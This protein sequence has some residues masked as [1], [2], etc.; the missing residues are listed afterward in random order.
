VGTAVVK[1]SL[2]GWPGVEAEAAEFEV[3][4]VVRKKVYQAKVSPRHRTAWPVGESWS[5]QQMLVTPNAREVSVLSSTTAWYRG[6]STYIADSY[7]LSRWEITEGQARQAQEVSLDK[8]LDLNAERE[9]F[10]ARKLPFR[11]GNSIPTISGAKFS[12][13]GRWV[14]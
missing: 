1:F 14:I 8:I 3:P 12:A 4:V 13:D 2:E 5:V 7:R 10:I 9:R 11:F 6:E